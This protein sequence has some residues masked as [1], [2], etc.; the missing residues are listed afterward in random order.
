MQKAGTRCRHDGAKLRVIATETGDGLPIMVYRIRAC[1]VCKD[2][3]VTVEIPFSG[4]FPYSKV[5]ALA[6]SRRK[7]DDEQ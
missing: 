2:R 1:P 4:D 5:K 7:D 6:A 3:T